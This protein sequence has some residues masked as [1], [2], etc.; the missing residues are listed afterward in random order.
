MQI[1]IEEVRRRIC[2]AP[3]GSAPGYDGLPYEFYKRHQET[4][5]PILAEAISSLLLDDEIPPLPQ[6]YP[7][8]LG[9]LLP[10]K[11]PEGSDQYDLKFKR[12]LNIADT[13]YRIASLVMSKRLHT[14]TTR[15]VTANQTAFLQHRGMEENGLTTYL[16]VDA[17][18]HRKDLFGTDPHHSEDTLGYATEPQNPSTLGMSSQRCHTL[19]RRILT[20]LHRIRGETRHRLPGPGKGLRPS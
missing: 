17:K 5:C 10:K 20:T 4:L 16:L 12:P 8:L 14:Y 3:N 15:L 6:Q 7:I 9:K 11:I 1:S 13:D 18:N 2:E 19:H